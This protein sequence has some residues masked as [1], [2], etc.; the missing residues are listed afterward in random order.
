MCTK[1]IDLGR[2]V[3]DINNCVIMAEKIPLCRKKLQENCLDSSD[4]TSCAMWRDYCNAMW[5]GTAVLAG[6]NW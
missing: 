2:A 3:L 6:V 4:Y 1:H 5:A